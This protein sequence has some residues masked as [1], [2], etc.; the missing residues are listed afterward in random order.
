MSAQ[1]L[2][3]KYPQDLHSQAWLLACRQPYGDVVTLSDWIGDVHVEQNKTTR[4]SRLVSCGHLNTV[5]VIVRHLLSLGLIPAAAAAAN[6]PLFEAAY[7][8]FGNGDEDMDSR[9]Q[10]RLLAN[11]FPN[12]TSM[13]DFVALYPVLEQLLESPL[14]KTSLFQNPTFLMWDH[15]VCQKVNGVFR[16]TTISDEDNSRRSLIVYDGRTPLSESV[17]QS[18]REKSKDDQKGIR[19]IT[20]FPQFLC[21]RYEPTNESVTQRR[22]D[23]LARFIMTAYSRDPDA[24]PS[25]P[26]PPVKQGRKY[27]LVMVVAQEK[28]NVEIRTYELSSR[29]VLPEHA[30]DDYDV[31][32]WRLGAPTHKYTLFYTRLDHEMPLEDS[33]EV[34]NLT[35]DQLAMWR[36]P[37]IRP[38]AAPSPDLSAFPGRDFVPSSS[39]AYEESRHNKKRLPSMAPFSEDHYFVPSQVVAEAGSPAGS[40]SGQEYSARRTLSPTSRNSSRLGAYDIPSDSPTDE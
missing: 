39:Q 30:S 31:T 13:K 21:I 9:V 11:M 20:A 32:S 1:D 4:A 3:K 18:I 29:P 2:R 36:Q 6:S 15:E 5:L 14:V 22:F 26:A 35:Q 16:T 34:Y 38:R 40:L 8:D 25:I 28:G 33:L 24:T 19:L 37:P 10:G 17:S 27:V 12:L 23:D 7:H